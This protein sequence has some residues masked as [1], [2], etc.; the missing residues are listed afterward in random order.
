[1]PV[2]LIAALAAGVGFIAGKGIDGAGKIVQ[3]GVIGAGAFLVYR[4]VKG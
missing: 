2:L 1:M 4:H 3:W